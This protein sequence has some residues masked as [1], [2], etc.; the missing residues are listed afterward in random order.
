ME[1]NA[2]GKSEF[3][4]LNEGLRPTSWCR[5]IRNRGL[6]ASLDWNAGYG[7]LNGLEEFVD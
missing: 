6:L 5:A 4:R 3:E 1:I 2:E 7:G